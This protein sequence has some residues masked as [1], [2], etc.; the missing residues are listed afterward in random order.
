[1][2]NSQK[3]IH[4]SYFELWKEKDIYRIAN[5]EKH[6]YCIMN[7]EKETIFIAKT[8]FPR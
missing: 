6:V 2:A 8:E 4:L 3:K 7:S 1:M 5:S